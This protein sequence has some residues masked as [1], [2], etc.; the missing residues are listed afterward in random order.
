MLKA[1]LVSI[2]EKVRFED[3]INAIPEVKNFTA[4]KGE[5]VAFQI[6]MRYVHTID[7]NEYPAC[8]INV[9]VKTKLPFKLYT[10]DLAPVKR[11][12]TVD[13][14]DTDYIYCGPTM[15]PDEMI[16]FENN[17]IFSGTQ[18][19]DAIVCVIDLPKD[20]NAGEYPI[21]IEL[22]HDN[23][24]DPY[25]TSLSTTVRVMENAIRESDLR[26]TNWFH[27][28][29][30][31]TYYNIPQ[32]SERH[33]EI[34]ENFVKTAV[35]TGMNMILTPIFTPALDTDRGAER[36]TFQLLKIEKNGDKYTFDFTLLER[37]VKMCLN[38]GIKYFEIAHLCTQWGAQFCPKIVVTENGEEKKL[39]GWHTESAGSEYKNFLSQMLPLLCDKLRELGVAENTYFHI[40]DEPNSDPHVME[41]ENRND[42]KHYSEMKAFISPLVKGFKLMDALSHVDFYD[43]GLIDIPVCATD[44]I[45]PFLERNIEEMWAYCCCIQC[46]KVPNRLIAMHSWRNRAHG[47]VMYMTG[48]KGFLHW[49][50][51]FYYSTRSRYPLNPRVGQ[52]DGFPSGDSFIVYPAA[53][54]TA[55]ETLRSEAFFCALQDYALLKMLEE[56]IGEDKTR[57]F[58]LKLANM[59]KIDFDNYPR[60]NEFYHT[61]HDELVKILG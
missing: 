35:H 46:G 48:V 4:L 55:N 32:M 7:W 37:W 1:K 12:A 50:F 61:L 21:D 57:D 59:Y 51:N 39:F 3:D 19:T 16:P 41:R 38:C 13:R 20:Y 23:Y 22:F 8:T 29:C 53:D 26:Y 43:A 40:S 9:N 34:I 24:E 10:L 18:G 42:F 56:K 47:V 60:N 54:G 36:P 11:F 17:T 58:V 6:A 45:N 49:G 25:K 33:W 14:A 2:L 52:L 15:L 27:C 31:A 28:D 30:L 5:R 44:V